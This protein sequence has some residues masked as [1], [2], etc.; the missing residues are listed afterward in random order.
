MLNDF[1]F[2][3]RTFRRAP[4]FVAIAI[5]S[6][7]LG[8]GANT[9]IF[10][11]FDQ[12]LLRSLPVADPGRLVLFHSEGQDPGWAMADNFETVYSYP[13]YKEFRDRSQVFD[14]VIARSGASATVMEPAGAANA[15]VELVSGNFFDVLGVRAAM[16]R[17]ILPS[18]DAAPGANPVVALG[19]GYWSGR[20]G[21]DPKVLNSRILVNG[22]P[23]T[24][25]GILDRRF[26]G[27]Q[28]GRT[29]DLYVPVSMKQQISPGRDALTDI[30][31]RWL[32]VIAR[33]K[34]GVS[35]DKAQAATRV[36][37]KAVRNENLPRMDKMDAPRLADYSR[38]TVDLHPAAEGINMLSA[39]WRKP[40]QV[41]MAMVGL[42]LLIA[43]ANLASLLI[44][45]AAAREREMAVR[46][47]IGASRAA[48]LRQL[49]TES[50]TLTVA[51]GFVGLLLAKWA[52]GGLLWLID[53]GDGPGWLAAHLDFRLFA[54]ALAVSALAGLV[55]GCAPLLQTWKLDLVTA[56]K[57]QAGTTA[58]SS[59]QRMRKALVAAQVAL[60][61]ALLAAAGLFAQTL[62]NLKRSNPGFQPANVLRFSI[63]PR[64]NGYD[65]DRAMALLRTVRERLAALPGVES[66][67][68]AALGP[69]SNGDMGTGIY[70]EGRLPSMDDEAST[71]SL[72]AGYFRT[73]RIPIV[74]GREF[75][76][77]ET[78]TG[79]KAAIVNQ[80]FAKKYFEGRNPLGLHVG[81]SR[82]HIEYEVVGIARDTAHGSLRDE[83]KPFVYF[84]YEQSPP[85][86]TAVYVRGYGP[87]L[88]PA[89]RATVR[90]IDANLPIM[91]MATMQ[92]RI[93]ESIRI[94]LSIATLAAGFGLLATLL[95]AVGL[96]GAV[97]YSVARR[98]VEIGVR[99]ALGAARADV[100]RMVMK[101]VG[102]LLLAGAAVG[103]PA[104]LALG[105]LVE[106]QLYGVKPHDPRLIAAAVAVLTLVALAA[107]FVPARRAASIDPV[108]ALRGE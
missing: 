48:I 5:A 32:N 4:G 43:C 62:A 34:P 107:A 44:A 11:V 66:V 57:E 69:F 73:L 16:G 39:F 72:S 17:T 90:Q 59:R 83:P 81:G 88:G 74:A 80:T 12:V 41:L 8:I 14:G 28:T 94:E 31:G 33:L 68:Y 89:V 70:V 15:G 79:P 54:Y 84:P 42:V 64:L 46:T 85:D 60:A 103:L 105:K 13:M 93:D 95:A 82:K 25:I 23:M 104:A 21:S 29:P 98:T 50:L 51:A 35:I 22:Q 6:L 61:L 45:R 38:R 91:N 87:Q 20:F 3:L 100:Y 78:A 40:L 71:D 86:A 2:A 19:G 52:V 26:L 27:V 96:Y 7:A 18:D 30:S 101:E 53:N 65:K 37:F 10:S 63:E 1:R 76:E 36:L 9:A 58:S 55:F 97:A 102:I 108:R 47:A 24:V 106:S 67:G 77:R 56:L 75:D 99:M 92:S 49:L